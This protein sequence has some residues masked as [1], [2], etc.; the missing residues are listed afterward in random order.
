M[1]SVHACG[2][3]T[4]FSSFRH[5]PTNRNKNH[6]KD[7]HTHPKSIKNP[8]KMVTKTGA[9]DGSHQKKS[10]ES[11]LHFCSPNYLKRVSK[12]DYFFPRGTF[13]LRPFLTC[14]S[15]VTPNR[16]DGHPGSHKYPKSPHQVRPRRLSRLRVAGNTCVF[17]LVLRR[18]CEINVF[19][20]RA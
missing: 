19:E 18:P 12:K 17:K 3:Q 10:P 15:K 1:Q 13:F 9:G 5:T 16:P 7:T 14:V 6:L 20:T 8:A 4:H 2:V 11:I